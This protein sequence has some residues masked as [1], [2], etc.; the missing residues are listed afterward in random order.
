MVE[1]PRVREGVATGAPLQS[2]VDA[3]GPSSRVPLQSEV[4]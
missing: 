1:Q 2:D 3:P 4:R